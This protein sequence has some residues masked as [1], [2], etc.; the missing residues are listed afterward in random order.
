MFFQRCRAKVLPDL[1]NCYGG[2][3]VGH[4]PR[5]TEIRSAQRD[6]LLRIGDLIALA[7]EPVERV[8]G[9]LTRSDDVSAGLLNPWSWYGR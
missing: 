4:A 2:S 7:A 1:R 5:K 8:V 6:V 9:D 3:T